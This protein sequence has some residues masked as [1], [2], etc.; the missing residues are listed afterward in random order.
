MPENDFKSEEA[1]VGIQGQV[2]WGLSWS[3]AVLPRAGGRNWMGFKIPSNP[4][5]SVI[6]N[7]ITYSAV[8]WAGSP[9][10]K[11]GGS[12]APLLAWLLLAQ[13]LQLSFLSLLSI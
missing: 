9:I 6:L 10:G 3:V 11:G 7:S 13:Q 12:M 1:S 4:G 5:H 2:G 8:A